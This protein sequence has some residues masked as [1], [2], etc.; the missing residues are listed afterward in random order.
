MTNKRSSITRH[1]FWWRASALTALLAGVTAGWP[2]SAQQQPPVFEGEIRPGGGAAVRYAVP[3][4]V[5]ATPDLTEVGRI[6]AQV[7]WN[8]LEFERELYMIPRDTYASIP[9]VGAGAIP[10]VRADPQ[11]RAQC[12]VPDEAGGVK[13]LSRRTVLRG[14]G[15]AVAQLLLE[16]LEDRQALR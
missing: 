15:A 5:P 7:L 13:A 9:R 10:V 3:D 16:R 12:A 1:S 4:F 6:L 14:A 11:R 2:L 8:D